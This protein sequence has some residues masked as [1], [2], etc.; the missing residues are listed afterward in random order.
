MN[1]IY[2][3]PQKGVQHETHHA[4]RN[5]RVGPAE[6]AHALSGSRTSSN[7][8]EVREFSI[9]LQMYSEFAL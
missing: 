4:D 3:N 6:L 8:R 7:R 5:G 1:L 9:E 2:L